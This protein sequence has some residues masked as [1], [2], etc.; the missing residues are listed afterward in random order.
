MG[1]AVKFL[2]EHNR[3]A[4]SVEQVA[5]YVQKSPN[6]FSALFKKETGVTFSQYMNQ[7]RLAEAKRLLRET[8][9][10]LSEIAVLAGYTDYAY[11][12][13]VFKKLEGCSPSSLRKKM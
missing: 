4:V 7:L 5:K 12:V 8:I 11:F 1:A 13:S 3:E 2:Q 6:Y 10:P 9:L